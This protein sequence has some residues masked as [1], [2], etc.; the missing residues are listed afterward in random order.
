[1]EQLSMGGGCP[2]E[3]EVRKGVGGRKREKRAKFFF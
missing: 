1:M 2:E 3:E